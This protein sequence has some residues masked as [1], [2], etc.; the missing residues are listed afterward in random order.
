[1]NKTT[2]FI[3]ITTIAFIIAGIYISFNGSQDPTITAHR[4]KKSKK[5]IAVKFQPTPTTY[6]PTPKISLQKPKLKESYKC[7]YTDNNTS[8]QFVVAY[9]SV[10]G[11]VKS[12]NESFNVVVSGDC[13][14]KW[15]EGENTGTKVCGM[16]KYNTL[17]NAWTVLPSFSVDA[18]VDMAYALEPT[19]YIDKEYAKNLFARC[20]KVV[21]DRQWMSEK[22]SIPFIQ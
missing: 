9:R 15:R 14:Y 11:T 17:L 12:N 6:R 22:T 2:K 7:E 10:Y 13:Y 4:A 16:N 1:M 18:L 5:N 21:V 8:S 20:T 19:V 3:L